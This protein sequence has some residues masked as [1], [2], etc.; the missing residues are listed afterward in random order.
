MKIKKYLKNIYIWTS[1]KREKKYQRIKNNIEQII[2]KNYSLIDK[3][4]IL[5]CIIIIDKNKKYKNMMM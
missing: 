1:N 4:M 3:N 5:I 2:K